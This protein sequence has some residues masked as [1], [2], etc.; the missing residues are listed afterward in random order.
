MERRDNLLIGLVFLSLVLLSLWLQFGLLAKPH[1][2]LIATKKID[3]DYYDYY[4][5]KF[6]TTGSTQHGKKYQLS[7]DRM[8]H[9][10]IGARASLDNPHIIQYD[11]TRDHPAQAP[12]HTYAESGWLYDDRVL[13]SGNVR[14]VQHKAGGTNTTTVKKMLIH[15]K[16]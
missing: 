8:V 7:A 13:L 5:E 1:N 15:L 3:A 6:T 11:L 4:I 12:K 16:K 14:I 10:P 9:Y 2:A